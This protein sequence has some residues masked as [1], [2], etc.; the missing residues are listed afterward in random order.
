MTNPHKLHFIICSAA[1][2]Q[3]LMIFILKIND[4]QSYIAENVIQASL[5]M[6]PFKRAISLKRC[7]LQDIIILKIPK[8]FLMIMITQTVFANNISCK[9]HQLKNFYLVK[10]HF[11]VDS[12]TDKKK[13]KTG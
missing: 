9:R 8:L 11:L 12:V 5:K 3:E 7:G 2:K 6:W 1:K 13:I 10:M 4:F